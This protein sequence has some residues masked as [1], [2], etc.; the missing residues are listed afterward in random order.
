MNQYA[1]RL[2]AT[3][4]PLLE[5]PA[6]RPVQFPLGVHGQGAGHGLPARLTREADLPGI[7]MDAHPPRRVRR[8]IARAG[9]SLAVLAGLWVALTG[10]TAQ[11]WMIGGPAILAATALIFLYPAPPRWRLSPVGALRFGPW[12]ALRLLLGALDV[13]RRALGRRPRLAPGCR[14]FRTRLPEGAPRL[15]FANVITLLP[16]TLTAGLH[17]ELLLIH[18]LDTDADL[19]AQ[20]RPLEARVA[21]LFRLRTVPPHLAL[22]NTP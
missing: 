16:G 19:E 22:E 18:M 6:S 20:L 17:D 2:S 3:P 12:F 14:V 21:A 13:A 1:D 7:V 15:L 10:G 4:Q 5:R 11:G 8:H 9:F